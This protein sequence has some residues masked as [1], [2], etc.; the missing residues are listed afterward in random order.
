M[1]FLQHPAEVPASSKSILVNSTCKQTRLQK[2]V[3]SVSLFLLS[4]SQN[5]KKLEYIATVRQTSNYQ[6]VERTAITDSYLTVNRAVMSGGICR[7]SEEGKRDETI[8]EE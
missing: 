6:N 7:T 3:V 8:N 2:V 1:E 5:K 4:F